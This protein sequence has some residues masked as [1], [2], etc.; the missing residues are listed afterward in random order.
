MKKLNFLLGATFCLA[1][2]WMAML[3]INLTYNKTNDNQIILQNIEAIAQG[4]GDWAC[5]DP[6]DIDCNG[7]KYRVK[8]E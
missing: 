5:L 8:F 6:G 3:H 1:G 2:I 7:G 4:E